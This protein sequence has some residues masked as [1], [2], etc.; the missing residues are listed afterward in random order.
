MAI[1]LANLKSDDNRKPPR[2]IVYGPE[3]VGKTTLGLGAPNAVLIKTEEGQGEIGAT[4][5][6]FDKDGREVARDFDEVLEAIKVLGEEEHEFKTLVID[7]ITSLEVLLH[8]QLCAR[9]NESNIVGNKKG[10]E[11]AFEAGIKLAAREWDYFLSCLDYLNEKR[12]MMIILVAHSSV[13]KFKSPD[14]EDFDYYEID[15]EKKF[16]VSVLKKWAD[17]ILFLRYEKPLLATEDKGFGKKVAK[18]KLEEEGARI[19]YTEPRSSH[20][21]K[22]RYGMPY[23]IPFPKVDAWKLLAPYLLKWLTAPEPKKPAPTSRKNK[24]AEKPAEEVPPEQGA[25]A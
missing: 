9:Y 1:S 20:T 16:S 10:S 19:L 6:T 2:V 17:A 18:A 15:V 3:G 12:G 5:F 13:A 25:A 23:E 14:T 8:R 22:N 21:A 7:S 24:P 11:F 4:R